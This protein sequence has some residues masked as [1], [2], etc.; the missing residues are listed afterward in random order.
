MRTTSHYL[1]N[2]APRR[3]EEEARKPTQSSLAALET[4]VRPLGPGLQDQGS[5]HR[6]CSVTMAG[7]VSITEKG[8]NNPSGVCW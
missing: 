4:R 8:G 6:K 1:D 2:G 5:N 7:V 3:R